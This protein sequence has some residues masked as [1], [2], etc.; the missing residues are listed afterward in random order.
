MHTAFLPGGDFLSAGTNEKADMFVNWELLT[1]ETARRVW[2][3]SLARF[4]D[5]SPFQTYDWG[6]YGRARG[7][8][9]CRWAARDGAGRIVAMAQGWLKRYPLGFGVVWCEGGPVGEITAWGD[10]LR[11]V[12]VRTTGLRRV[13]CRFRSDRDRHVS[14]A[15]HLFSQG[16]A[17]S[18]HPLTS[19]WS[20]S[21]DLRLPEAEQLAAAKRQWRRNLRAAAAATIHIRQWHDP[22]A[23]DLFAV[24]SAMQQSKKLEEQ[25]SLDE[26]RLLLHH[27]GHRLV[28]F[29][30]LN[31]SG[32]T[33]SLRGCLLIGDRAWDLLAATNEEGREQCASYPLLL[34]LMRHCRDAGVTHYDLGGIDPVRNPGVYRFKRGIGATPLEYL[35][36]WDWAPSAW[37]RVG[38]NLA[39]WRRSRLRQART[40]PTSRRPEVVAWAFNLVKAVR[41]QARRYLTIG[42]ACLSGHLTS[43][44]TCLF[45]LI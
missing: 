36:E 41:A 15:L 6:E 29:R 26:L 22:S 44:L 25:Y 10:G 23:E 5:Y 28:L 20:V 39:I 8:E 32:R 2:D 45:D 40:R 13:Y 9:V 34:A 18:L 3:S 24:Y 11:Q 21:L 37:I 14:D 33:I 4:A 42:A 12:I 27:L 1:D 43:E 35:G 17:R 31:E 7:W 19:N 16:W 38:M 30:C